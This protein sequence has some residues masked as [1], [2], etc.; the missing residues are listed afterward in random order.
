MGIYCALDRRASTP[1][2]SML[3]WGS[4]T[5]DFKL[6]PK[7]PDLPVVYQPVRVDHPRTPSCCPA[8]LHQHHELSQPNT[9]HRRRKSFV[10]QFV[11]LT[12]AAIALERRSCA[13]RRHSTQAT[14][15]LHRYAFG[16]LMST[17]ESSGV[18]CPCDLKACV[19]QLLDPDSLFCGLAGRR[20]AGRSRP[21]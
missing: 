6:S 4:P 3:M 14:Q 13:S 5:I 8:R 19:L 15:P 11:I 7:R 17:C 9:R 12:N 1:L 18:C 21:V 20:T 16:S 10:L 2:F